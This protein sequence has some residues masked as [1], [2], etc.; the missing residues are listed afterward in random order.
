MQTLKL[1]NNYQVAIVGGGPVGLFLGCCL[2]RVGIS[3]CVFEKRAGP[4]THSRSI[5]IHPVSLECFNKI[6][7]ANSFT[8]EGIKVTEGYAYWKAQK[9][10]TI[11]FAACPPPYRFILTIPQS[12][13]EQLLTRHLNTLDASVLQRNSKVIEINESKDNILLTIAQNGEPKTITAKYIVGCDGMNSFVRKKAT[14]DF[15]GKT[16][17]DTYIMGDFSDNTNLEKVAAVFL[18]KEGLVE[19]FPLPA[20]NRRWVVKTNHLIDKVKRSDIERRVKNRINFSLKNTENS[21]LSSF[22]VFDRKAETM[23]KGHILLAG[24]AAH[25]VSPIGGQGMNLGW[26]DAYELSQCFK[27]A[28]M[29]EVKPERVFQAYSKRRLSAAKKA[30]RRAAFN[31][32]LGRKTKFPSI[33]KVLLKA[34]VKPPV[35]KKMARLFTMRY[36]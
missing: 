2:Q 24:D 35:S 18:S 21:M 3:T 34:I 36:I 23:A 4:T 31:M 33:K 29:G 27:K 20:S 14:I 10:G 13:T 25:V 28:F 6:G 15:I 12:K 26:L 16:Y 19:S 17:N 11:S 1:N 7:L 9:V 30:A 32:A 8:E 22:G 5:G